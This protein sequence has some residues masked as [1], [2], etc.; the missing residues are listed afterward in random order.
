MRVTRW[1][2][3][4]LTTG[5]AILSCF[6]PVESS[7]V[8]S[9]YSFTAA[10]TD[11]L[12]TTSDDTFDILL[13]NFNDSSTIETKRNAMSVLFR[14]AIRQFAINLEDTVDKEEIIELF[15]GSYKETLSSYC[16]YCRMSLFAFRKLIW[17][18]STEEMLATVIRRGCSFLGL[19]S[20]AMCEG[21]TQAFKVSR[22]LDGTFDGSIN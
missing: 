5:L 22:H 13:S 2:L 14:R 16:K 11:D 6:K 18:Y 4:T 3:V 7:P 17:I 19:T 15:V 12:V 9:Q 10:T 1:P 21:L 8:E 20:D